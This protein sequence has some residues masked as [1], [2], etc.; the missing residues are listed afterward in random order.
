[1][2]GPEITLM[3]FSVPRDGNQGLKNAIFRPQ[4]RKS[5]SVREGKGHIQVTGME[6]E[7]EGDT[8]NIFIMLHTIICKLSMCIPV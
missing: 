5:R 4:R 6:E 1:M 7:N 8:E 3:L 2:T